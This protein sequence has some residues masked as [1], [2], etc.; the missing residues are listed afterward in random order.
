MHGSWASAIPS[1]FVEELPD[2]RVERESDVGVYSGQQM[3]SGYG[4][5]FSG[6]RFSEDWGQKSL[7]PG[8]MRAQ[9]FRSSPATT[10]APGKASPAGASGGANFARGERVFHQKFGYGTI[11]AVE[12]DRLSIAFDMAGE[13]KVIA[14]FIVPAD[15]AG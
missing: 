11:A 4:G 8:M 13:K 6:G 14:S 10:R 5:G 2:E 9:S 3:Q 7:S 15:Q 12:G 1:R